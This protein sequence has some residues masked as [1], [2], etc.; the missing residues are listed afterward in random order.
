MKNFFRNPI[1]LI[2]LGGLFTY[3]FLNNANQMYFGRSFGMNLSS[4]SSTFRGQS[5]DMGMPVMESYGE[6]SMA[7]PSK[8]ISPIMP[9]IDPYSP[10]PTDSDNRLV[11]TDTDLSMKVDDVSG[12]IK[13]IGEIA[14]ASNGFVIN[15]STN[16]PTE[17]ATGYITMRVPSDQKDQVVEQIKALGI[18]VTSEYISGT[19]VTDQYED[20]E[21]RR[22]V[23]EETKAKFEA[24]QE[25]ATEIQ[26]LLEVQRELI[27]IQSQLDSLEGRTR[28]LEQS[29]SLSRITVNLATDELALPLT[30]DQ[31]WR[32]ALA[33][34]EAVRSLLTNLRSMG[35]SLIWLSVY[36]VLFIP[37]AII[38]YLVW[39]RIANRVLV[40]K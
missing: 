1:V 27:N 25:S 33:Y 5:Y 12:T 40:N 14:K 13:Q 34:K 28:Y 36:S 31:A 23:L 29:A 9:P 21:A 16:N 37:V 35:Y 17:A 19:D 38:G 18:K 2:L 32:P 26:D 6:D 11:I 20:L 10:P 30:P 39:R 7:M 4:P 24:I 15:S 3:L 22:S 8:G